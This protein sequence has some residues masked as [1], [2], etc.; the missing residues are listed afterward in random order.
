MKKTFIFLLLIL[1]TFNSL[2]SSPL[3]LTDQAEDYYLDFDKVDILED[4]NNEWD[5]DL[6]SSP[7]MADRFQTGKSRFVVNENPS[8]TYWVRFTVHD[9]SKTP[10]NWLVESFM[11]NIKSLDFYIPTGD[12]NY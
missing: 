5:I 3:T 6:V 10:S 9:N 1:P 12:G 4:K 11:F 8:S 2:S 7:T